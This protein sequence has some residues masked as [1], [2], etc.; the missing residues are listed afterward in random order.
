MT[1]PGLRELMQS[2][3]LQASE[4][5]SFSRSLLAPLP[6]RAGGEAGDVAGAA[7]AAADMAATGQR[8]QLIQ[9]Q[10]T[11]PMSHACRWRSW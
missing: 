11:G 9:P 4:T 1:L 6:L 8:D 10:L 3:L 7:R 5:S 2:R